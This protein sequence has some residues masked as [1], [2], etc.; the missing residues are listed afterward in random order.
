MSYS[1]NL[2]ALKTQLN[3]QSPNVQELEIKILQVT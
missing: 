1:E 2:P 3:Q